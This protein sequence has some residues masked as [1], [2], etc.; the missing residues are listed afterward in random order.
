M[1]AL[2]ADAE[3]SRGRGSYVEVGEFL[4]HRHATETFGV[5]G[6]KELGSGV[7]S[8]VGVGEGVGEGIELEDIEARELHGGYVNDGDD[9]DGDDD[10]DDDAMPPSA[11]ITHTQPRPI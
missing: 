7:R 8:G 9:D 11:A 4:D 1:R 6:G 10:D 2:A 3:E 5:E